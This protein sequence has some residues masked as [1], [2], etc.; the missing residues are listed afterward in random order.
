M[1]LIVSSIL[2][3]AILS[4]FS[5]KKNVAPSASSDQVTFT[6]DDKSASGSFANPKGKV[7]FNASDLS[8]TSID[9]CIKAKTISSGDAERDK[10]LKN[11]DFFEVDKYPEITFKSTSAKKKTDGGYIIKGDFT[12]KDVTKKIEIPV[13]IVEED[14]KKYLKGSLSMNRIDYNIGSADDGVGTSLTA[15]LKYPIK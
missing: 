6:M 10:H 8:E 2:A 15:N 14:G 7:K 13:T 12:M 9:I 1:K 3:I 4:V 5:F 11:A